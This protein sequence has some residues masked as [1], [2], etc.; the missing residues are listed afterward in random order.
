M[1]DFFCTADLH[2]LL[3]WHNYQDRLPEIL[4]SIEKVGGNEIVKVYTY[5]LYNVFH[6]SFSLVFLLPPFLPP[7]LLFL[8]LLPPFLPFL[9]LF[10]FSQ[11]LVDTFNALFAIIEEKG[12]KYGDPVFEAL[13]LIIGLLVVEKYENFRPV[14]DTY[15]EKHFNVTSIH[16]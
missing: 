9:S 13:I 11:F 14:L 5:L 15:C 1:V 4:K 2:R 7:F 10:L 16:T 12:E 6:L 3:H 8:L